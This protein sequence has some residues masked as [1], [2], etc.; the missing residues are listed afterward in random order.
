M[1]DVLK[2]PAAMARVGQQLKQHDF[3][4]VLGGPVAGKVVQAA[5]DSFNSQ[6]SPMGDDWPDRKFEG[7]GHPLLTK[8]G[9]LKQAAVG[10]GPGNIS[11]ATDDTLEYGVDA[12]RLPQAG[13]DLGFPARNIVPRRYLGLSEQSQDQVAEL[14]ADDAQ[15][16]FDV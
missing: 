1:M 9:D 16:V 15:E 2:L 12:N 5:Q 8:S 7:D 13:H 10:Q 6:A 4:A 11:R 14:I 3:S